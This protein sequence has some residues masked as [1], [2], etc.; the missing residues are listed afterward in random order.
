MVIGLNGVQYRASNFKSTKWVVCGGF[1]IMSMIT[2]ELY[3]TKT[4]YHLI[5]LVTKWEIIRS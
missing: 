4:N 2:P 5:I 3:N 1:E